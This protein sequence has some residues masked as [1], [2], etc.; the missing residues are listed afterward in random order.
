MIIG[1]DT[2]HLGMKPGTGG[3]QVM[4]H[5]LRALKE[6]AP[7]LHVAVYNDFSDRW[8]RTALRRAWAVG[9]GDVIFKNVVLPFWSRRHHVDILMHYL[10][11]CSFTASRTPQLCFIYDVPVPMG[12]HTFGNHIYDALFLRGS[13]CRANH[14]LTIS[15]FSAERISSCYGIPRENVSVVHPCVDFRIFK[16][17]NDLGEL[18]HRLSQKGV[19]PGFFFAVLSSLWPRKNPG[20][21]LE[22]Y[23]RI[24]PEMRR[25]RKLVIAGAPRSLDDFKS[26]VSPDV[27]KCVARDVIVMGHVNIDDL[28]RL[29]TLAGV[30]LFLSKYEGL[31]LPVVE[32]LACGTP[33]VA[34]THPAVRE[35]GGPAAFYCD[36]DQYD[37]IARRCER[38]VEHP[39]DFDGLRGAAKSWIDRFSYEKHA[40]AMCRI[41][42]QIGRHEE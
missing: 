23:A 25:H 12:R 16:P 14:L 39:E 13:A 27:L 21:Y 38:A 10:P 30:H 7:G 8:N 11:P 32:A 5:S 20:A 17:R 3:A 40:R 33:A 26:L 31:G 29:Y 6:H 37:E 4:W 15:N 9:Y 35:A 28:A 19:R 42:E 22:A 24:K 36:P 1:V 34:S 2:R 41:F 18:E